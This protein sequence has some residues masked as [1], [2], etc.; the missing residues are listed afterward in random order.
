MLCL[1]GGGWAA[2]LLL[3]FLSPINAFNISNTAG[4]PSHISCDAVNEEFFNSHLNP[5][6]VFLMGLN[7][8]SLHSKFNKLTELFDSLGAK[9][10]PPDILALQ[11]TF[12]SNDIPPPHLNGYHPLVSSNRMYSKGGGVGLYINKNYSFSKNEKLSLFLERTFEALACDIY[13]GCRRFTIISIYR[14]PN[15]PSL[16][17]SEHFDAFLL[18]LHKLL[19]IAPK[20]TF[21]LLD[22]NINLDVSSTESLRYSST[23]SSL[24]FRNIINIHTRITDSTSS[25]I[26]QILVNCDSSGQSGTLLTDISDHLPTFL[27]SNPV[28]ARPI[29]KNA[30]T[31]RLFT[32]SNIELFLTHLSMVNWYSVLSKSDTEL[33][34][35]EFDS[36]WSMLF[37]QCFPLKNITLNRRYHKINDFFSNGLLISRARKMHL[38]NNFLKSRSR[39][40]KSLYIAY[41][42]CYNKTVKAAKKQFFNWKIDQ[43]CDPKNAW[44]Y[45]SEA[46]GKNNKPSSN[47]SCVNK[48]GI[49]I[50]D[51]ADIA[52]CFNEFFS[53]IAEKIVDNIPPTNVNFKDYIPSYPHNDFGFK[54]ID[55]NKLL[56]VINGLE[57]KSTLDINGYSTLLVKRAAN[58]ILEPLTYII[59]LSLMT[60]VFPNSLKLS[61]VCPIY[62]QGDRKD[63]N[64]YRPIS[65]LSSF[66]KIFE[67]VAYEQLS[68]FLT[69]HKILN[70]NQFGF[71]K[72]KSTVDALTKIMNFISEA[73]NDNKF[74]VA[75]FLDYQKAFDLV[76]HNILIE[77]LY[78]LGV[79]G[80]NL[81]W[82]RSYLSNR[83]MRVM[84]N[85]QL[86][87]TEK[88]INRSVPQGSILGPLLF[89]IFINDMPNCTTLLSILFADDTTVLA[90]GSDIS[91]V[92][93]MINNE[94]NKIGVWLKAN[95]L[96]INTIKTKIMIFSNNKPIPY[97]RFLFNNNDFNYSQQNPD[98]ITEVERIDSKSANPFFKMLGVL[99][100][101]K[102][103]FDHHCTKVLKKINS[104][105]FMINRA[106]HILSKN[107]LRRLYFAMI[108][109]HLL[110]CLPIYSCTSVKNIEM[111]HK[112][113]KQCL[114]TICNAKFNAHSEPLFYNSDI[115]PI[116]DLI[117]QQKLLFLHPIAHALSVSELSY[118]RKQSSVRGHEYPLRNN[119]DFHVPRSMFYK[120]SKMPL[121][122]FPSTWNRLD[123]SVK[124]IKSKSIFKKQLKLF[125]MDNYA[126]FQC[127]K[128]LCYSCLNIV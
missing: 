23:Y 115:L 85:G 127:H 113:Q 34:L 122:D 86:S 103:S 77:K 72:G 107:S 40:D 94:L 55:K 24:G 95:E 88:T 29:S 1:G 14:P 2:H 48:N 110:Y 66:S 75:T 81:N 114:R 18:N 44:N 41:R 17:K 78:S 61:R 118:F 80:R 42:N 106:K 82:F 10:K 62:K 16:S 46:I 15:S 123:D 117:W 32:E 65:C 101:E 7:I 68:N 79:R 96:S 25:S 36:I 11:E 45:L 83:K 60:G 71:Q 76:S 126:N 19:S 33:S 109:P 92:G 84:V 67:K 119:N 28:S 93:P 6:S 47:I 98:L 13:T 21:V 99:F 30:R 22:S 116:K 74:V 3:R 27:V 111:L 97:F 4:D 37:E 50:T 100:D 124:T 64:N 105:L 54:S 121:I 20:N 49:P 70:V 128:T 69:L 63:T 56:E 26:D 52:D 112:K 59:N 9:F 5:N 89:L 57:T 58:L 38:Y 120:V 43:N 73:F 91:V 104:A 31:R 125:C 35:D 39:D 102:L 8:Q 108:H 90:S 51:S 12:L 87:S 53:S